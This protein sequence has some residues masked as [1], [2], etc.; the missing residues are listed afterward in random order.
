MTRGDFRL[1]FDD[2]MSAVLVRN[3][4]RFAAIPTIE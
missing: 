2:G 1:V 4:S 3:T